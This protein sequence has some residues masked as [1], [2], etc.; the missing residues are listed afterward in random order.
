LS[1]SNLNDARLKQGGK[2]EE[3]DSTIAKL[4][5]ISAG[6]IDKDRFE[7]DRLAPSHSTYMD[8]PLSIV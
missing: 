1:G 7:G 2:K 6:A 3:K 8:I 5:A 4:R